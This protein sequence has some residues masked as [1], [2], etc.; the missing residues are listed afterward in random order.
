MTKAELMSRLSVRY[1]DLGGKVL[2]SREVNQC[3]KI[4]IDTMTRSLVNGQRVEIRGFGSFDVTNRAARIGRNPKTGVEV[5]IPAKVVP[6]F[7]VGKELRE[8][9]NASAK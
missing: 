6:H 1:A 8:R 2:K 3:V 5:H 9:V 4:I 7:K